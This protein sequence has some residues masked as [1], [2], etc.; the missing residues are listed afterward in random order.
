MPSKKYRAELLRSSFGS[1]CGARSAALTKSQRDKKT[2]VTTMERAF[3]KLLNVRPKLPRKTDSAKTILESGV[4]CA[5]PIKTH[6]NKM[7]FSAQVISQNSR[8]NRASRIQFHMAISILL[9][10]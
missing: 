3:L 8:A 7:A 1:Y 9:Q 4:V 10:D 6:K 2:I 5:I